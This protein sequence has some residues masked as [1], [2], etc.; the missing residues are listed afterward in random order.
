MAEKK[1]FN[2][3]H[4]EPNEIN[5]SNTKELDKARQETHITA[6]DVYEKEIKLS[7]ESILKPK[8]EIRNKRVQLLLT[9][10]NHLKIKE[11]A[12]NSGTSVND[13]LNQIIESL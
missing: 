9:E 1:E 5:K 12:A 6:K 11:Y 3:K 13:A 10:S 8:A 7:K 2:F 4:K